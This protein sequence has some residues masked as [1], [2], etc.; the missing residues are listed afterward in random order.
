MMRAGLFARDVDAQA[1]R[2]IPFVPLLSNFCAHVSVI[3]APRMSSG[4]TREK[5]F[6]AKG[7]KWKCGD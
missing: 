6:L 1:R 5:F 3:A 2:F 4:M 7:I